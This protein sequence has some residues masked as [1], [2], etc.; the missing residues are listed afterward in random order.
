MSSATPSAGVS[1][2]T[3]A[4]AVRQ[5]SASSCGSMVPSAKLA[6]RSAPESNSSREEFKCTRSIRP[7]IA[8]IRSTTPTSSS[9]PAQARQVSRQKPAPKSPLEIDYEVSVP[10][11]ALHGDHLDL[12]LEADG[13][14]MGH[15]HLQLL[16]GA[17]IRI[18]EAVNRH[19]GSAAELAIFNERNRA[20]SS[21]RGSVAR[22][23]RC[24]RLKSP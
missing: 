19:F 12:A 10:A 7:V 24:Q 20:T 23:H 15:T 4:S 22:K 3:G 14:Q 2:I 21:C 9:P 13:V 8:L 16:R 5:T 1:R 6:C 17:S 18:R 11:D